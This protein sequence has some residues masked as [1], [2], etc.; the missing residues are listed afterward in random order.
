MFD[1]I[2]KE[3]VAPILEERPA[4]QLMKLMNDMLVAAE[5][6]LAKRK[7]FFKDGGEGARKTLTELKMAAQ[8]AENRILPEEQSRPQYTIPKSVYREH[9]RLKKVALE[10]EAA[11]LK[12]QQDLEKTRTDLITR[13]SQLSEDIEMKQLEKVN[14]Q[15]EEIVNT[16]VKLDELIV[17]KDNL[18]RQR[19]ELELKANGGCCGCVMTKSK[20]LAIANLAEVEG[21]LN[22]VN[23]S[24]KSIIKA[25]RT[26]PVDPVVQ[27][28][29]ELKAIR[30]E[31]KLHDETR[32]EKLAGKQ[33]D[34]DAA[35]LN[36]STK[37]VAMRSAEEEYYGQVSQ[38]TMQAVLG[39]YQSF[40]RFQQAA[41][42]FL[43]ST[44]SISVKL[45]A[46]LEQV[47]NVHDRFDEK[48]EILTCPDL[49]N[50]S[51]KMLMSNPSQD[52]VLPSSIRLSH[53]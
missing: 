42:Q 4:Y 6:A 53:T 20:R 44:G 7:A 14:E 28:K 22:D 38:P 27:L 49:G 40:N 3:S 41:N 37:V 39:L 12:L 24:M 52:A 45:Q 2:V 29:L 18:T 30:A 31:L 51:A 48:I 11:L 13:Q 32:A 43:L 1:R 46:F 47:K 26:A 33:A 35:Q 16:N 36:L 23:A 8:A 19:G 5:P 15:G 34:V 25:S 17:Q 21:H 9:E 10:A 50:Q